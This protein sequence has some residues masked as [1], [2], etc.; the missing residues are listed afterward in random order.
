MLIFDVE[1]TGLDEEI[2]Q[3]CQLSYMKVDEKYNIEYAKNF[4]FSVDRMER[5]AERTHGL[6][7]ELLGELSKGKTFKDYSDEIY[8]DFKDEK[9]LY[10]GHNIK[11]DSRFL[12]KEFERLGLECD[13]LYNYKKQFCTMHSYTDI[14]AISYNAYYG[15]YKWPRL[16]E[17]LEYLKINIEDIKEKTKEIFNIDDTDIKAHDSRYDVVATREIARF[18]DE[19]DRLKRFRR[20]NE[21][22]CDIEKSLE[23]IKK[24][25]EFSKEYGRDMS[26]YDLE[27]F[28]D[29]YMNLDDKNRIYEIAKEGARA[30][31]SLANM[32]KDELERREKVKELE[33]K[34]L[35]EK[36][37]KE[38]TRMKAVVVYKDNW[39]YSK[40]VLS[41]DVQITEEEQYYYNVELIPLGNNKYLKLRLNEDSNGYDDYCKII[42]VSNIPNTEEDRAFDS[43]KEEFDILY[44]FFTPEF[45]NKD[46]ILKLNVRDYI[47]VNNST[48][49]LDEI[50]ELNQKYPYDDEDDDDIPF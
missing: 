9:D 5:G 11:F 19:V 38:G 41:Y 34:E 39:E 27:K 46:D 33:L 26:I 25:L 14:V 12:G 24:C 29:F 47:T 31:S 4:Y 3:I 40:E 6:S 30:F 15:S 35:I 2:N 50:N 48:P 36:G 17:I 20:I 37:I 18:Y 8:A 49:R 7:K 22:I 43:R 1:T 44:E 23:K 28:N 42:E 32:E 21:N 16:E 13:F 10:I 45:D